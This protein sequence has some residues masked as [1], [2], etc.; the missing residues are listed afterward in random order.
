MLLVVICLVGVGTI[1]VWEIL[2]ASVDV[3]A[4]IEDGLV[5]FTLSHTKVNGIMGITVEDEHGQP[6]WSVETSDVS[7]YKIT[8]GV[9]PLPTQGNIPARQLFPPDGKAPEDIRGRNVIVDIGY[10]YDAGLSACGGGVAKA[11][12]IPR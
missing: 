3:S 6:L 12:T 7:G 10:Q 2:P 5:V 8:Y 11:I 4:S 9:L 1:L